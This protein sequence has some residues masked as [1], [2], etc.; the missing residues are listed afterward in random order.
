MAALRS[1][2]ARL[3]AAFA[4][5]MLERGVFVIGFSFPVSAVGWGGEGEAREG[6][7]KG[8]ERYSHK[9]CIHTHTLTDSLTH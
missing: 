6:G 4:D 1:G 7:R 8:A 3:A 5:D 2:D 9:S